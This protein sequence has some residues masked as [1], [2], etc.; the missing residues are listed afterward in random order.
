MAKRRADAAP[1][2]SGTLS[3]RVY[4]NATPALRVFRRVIGKANYDLNTARAGLFE[5][6]RLDHVPDIN[7]AVDWSPKDLGK[8]AVDAEDFVVKALFVYAVDALDQYMRKLVSPPWIVKDE[9]T[10][11]LLRADFQVSPT[12]DPPTTAEVLALSKALATDPSAVSVLIKD[13][14]VKHLDR[15]Y[16]PG[17]RARFDAL[18]SLCPSVPSHHRAAVHI[19]VAWRNRHVHGDITDTVSPAIEKD[20]SDGLADLRRSNPRA[21]ATGLLDRFTK[22]LGPLPDDITTLTALLH[23]TV[24]AAD[25]DLRAKADAE[26]YAVGAVVQS[27]HAQDDPVR[28][29]KDL[30]GKTAQ[31]RA[32]K[33]L[34]MTF[35]AGFHRVPRARLPAGANAIPDE[36]WL[37]LANLGRSEFLAEM[38]SRNEAEKPSTLLD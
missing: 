4:L 13:F 5:L 18:M 38:E 17:M 16:R 14:R 15:T 27:F 9:K 11:S 3:Y 10:L 25:S 23:R 37:R 21:D 12:T 33:L 7:F 24:S 22:G 30:W 36:L 1:E 20:W 31:F 6:A 19:L 35:Q 8:V 28:F 26:A 29:A 34:S 32:T 2:G